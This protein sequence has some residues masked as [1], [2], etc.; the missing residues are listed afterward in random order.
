MAGRGHGEEFGHPLDDSEDDG[1]TDV[2]DAHG[3][4][5]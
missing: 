5:F 4:Q 1:L 2:D 3:I